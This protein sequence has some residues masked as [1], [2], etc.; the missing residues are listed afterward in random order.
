MS[1][2]RGRAI[3]I[4]LF[5][6]FLLEFYHLY[7]FDWLRFS[8]NRLSALIYLGPIFMLSKGK[9]WKMNFL[10]GKL[11]VLYIS[12]AMLNIFTCYFY[13]GQSID[14]SLA[15][16]ASLL[17]VFYYIPFRSWKFDICVWEKVVEYMY[18][19]L[20]VLY[21]LKYIFMDWQ[22]IQLDTVEDY[23]QKENR[24][25]IYSDAF[26]E[27]G[28]LYCL[29][30]FLMLKKPKYLF[31]SILGFFFIFMQGFRALVLMGIVVSA[32]MIM[33]VY[34][35]S[36]GYMI[37][38]AISI[39]IVALLAVQIP[40]VQNKIDELTHRNETQNFQNEDYIRL[41][42]INYTYSSL[43]INKTEM[44][45]GAGKTFVSNLKNSKHAMSYLSDYSKYRT[46]LATD[47]SYYPVDLGF[48]GL[49]WEAGIPFTII[50]ILLFIYLLIIKVNKEYYYL[51]L[52]GLY[53]ILIGVTHPQ[54]YYYC[55]SICL[56]VAYTI[57][58]IA[59]KSYKRKIIL[60]TG[61]DSRSENKSSAVL[62]IDVDTHRTCQAP[63]D[64][65]LMQSTIR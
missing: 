31:F 23:L 48:I 15:A 25:R 28:Y 9:W 27:L 33:R 58:E 44:V 4:C 13:R 45:L 42:D 8:G 36:L 7:I 11:F 14:V 50:S 38:T 57:I 37:I 53:M 22:F 55:N 47:Y 35:N 41:F 52:Y 3:F 59:N 46:R 19:F 30:K 39:I 43:F 5:L 60:L 2:N 32:I 64:A 21:A 26:L 61:G 12:F 18:L 40:V 34:K 1:K 10:A 49:S 63:A 20:L 51:G 65:K 17:L 54:G 29:N 6:L 56:A 24:V 62:C 16:W